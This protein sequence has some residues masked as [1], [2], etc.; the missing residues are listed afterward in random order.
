MQ[1]EARDAALRSVRRAEEQVQVV[2]LMMKAG[3]PCEH[4]LGKLHVIQG[5]LSGVVDE[6]LRCEALERMNALANDPAS[7]SQREA[8]YQ[9]SMIYAMLLRTSVVRE[10]GNR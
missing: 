5:L 7:L 1:A 2:L 8:V 9:L 3:E 6:M 10:K 4:L